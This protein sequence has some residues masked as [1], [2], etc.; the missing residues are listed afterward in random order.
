MRFFY[1]GTSMATE[2]QNH[3]KRPLTESIMKERTTFQELATSSWP[4]ALTA[5]GLLTNSA[6]VAADTT[7]APTTRSGTPIANK[8][9][10]S[11]WKR[12][13]DAMRG[14]LST[15]AYS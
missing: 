5:V 12:F 14:D 7:N 4:L 1:T 2:K 6:I 15:P 11:F 8:A 3:Q 13:D 9:H 10:E